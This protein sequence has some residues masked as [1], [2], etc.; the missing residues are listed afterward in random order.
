MQSAQSTNAVNTQPADCTNILSYEKD[1]TLPD[2]TH[3]NAGSSLDKQW[4]VKNSGTCN[5]D[6][7]YTIRM[8][9]GDALG[10]ASPQ[11]LDPVSSGAETT[12]HI[13]FTAPSQAGNYTSSW[14]AYDPD[15]EAF[16]DYFSIEINVTNP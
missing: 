7:T 16:G 15:G 8:L 6:K 4:Q 2:G 14:Q 1:L 10:A 11:T 5:W 3:V 13:H 9:K 12:I